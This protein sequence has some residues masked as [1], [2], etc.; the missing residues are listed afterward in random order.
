MEIRPVREGDVGA[1][2]RITN[3]YIRTTPIHF[4]WSEVTEQELCSAWHAA[5]A[6]YP[7][8]VAEE[9]GRVI[10]YCK[11]GPWRERF[12]YSWTAEA[13]L[14]VHPDHQRR[15]AGTAMYRDVI[16][17][18]RERGFHSLVGGVVLPNEASVRLHESLGF[19]K[20]GEF[21][22]VG[23]KF[24]QWHDVGFWQLSLREPGH[25]PLAP[26]GRSGES[27]AE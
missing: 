23:W 7:W 12:A 10:G 1:I 4:A 20:V 14:Y 27:G 11:A 9:D 25:V 18:C 5:R 15:G 13:G 26:P 2:A 19:T 17:E 24:G 16:R 6:V 21:R 22:Q 8:V 3:F